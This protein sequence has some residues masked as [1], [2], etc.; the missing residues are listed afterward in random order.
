M[1]DNSDFLSGRNAT[2]GDYNESANYDAPGNRDIP[3]SGNQDDNSLSGDHGGSGHGQA[4][5]Y[6][7]SQNGQQSF[8]DK[9]AGYDPGM[10]GCGYDNNQDCSVPGA[11]RMGG[12]RYESTDYGRSG[13]LGTGATPYGRGYE[14]DNDEYDPSPITDN[15]VTTAQ[16]GKPPLGARVKGGVE[17]MA[18]KVI[19]DPDLEVKGAQ[20]QTGQF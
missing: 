17:K 9:Y 12:E 13:G 14:R 3:S 7:G 16:G 18:G 6:G 1:S 8:G 11:G 19:R 4:R 10:A 15:S 2:R 5:G 20:H